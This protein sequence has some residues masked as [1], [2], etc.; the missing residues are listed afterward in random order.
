MIDQIWQ[1][2]YDVILGNP[3]AVEVL[4]KRSMLV[5]QTEDL[6]QE[7]KGKQVKWKGTKDYQAEV[8]ME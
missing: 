4:V 7:G 5:D 2:I 1:F 8:C 3:F 6:F